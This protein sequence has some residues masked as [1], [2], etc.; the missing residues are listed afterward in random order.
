MRRE[1]ISAYDL[2]LPVPVAP[3]DERRR[4]VPA[5]VWSALLRFEAALSADLGPALR[6]VRLFGSYARNDF[7]ALSDVDV[8]V[9]VASLSPA[10]RNRIIERTVESSTSWA[11]SDEPARYPHSR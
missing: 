11:L 7:D 3:L 2:G 9:V 10:E 5:A 4:G 1:E 8:V 6:K